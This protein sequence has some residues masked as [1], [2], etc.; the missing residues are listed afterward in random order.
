MTRCKTCLQPDTKPDLAF[1]DGECSACINYANRPEIDWNARKRELVNILS[2]S[3]RNSSG[4]DCIVPSSGG[5]DS[6]A[7]VLTLL[8]LGVRPLV[9]T[10][11]TDFLTPIGR[12]NI[13]NL[14]RYAT[15]IEVT[16]NRSVRARLNRLGL[17]L[18]GD[19]CWPEH[20]SIFTVPFRVAK[21][22]D[23]PLIFYGENPQQEYGGP[24]GAEQARHMTARWVSEYGGFLGLRPSDF[25]GK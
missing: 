14:A 10:A 18:V 12:A 24:L 1:V 15:T 17:E 4:Y 3:P 22:M 20:A 11:T 5:K 7:Q 16:P 2:D 13:D 6:H 8:E 23:I 9:V 21:D 19:I 25:I